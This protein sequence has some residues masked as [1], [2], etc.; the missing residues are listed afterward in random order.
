MFV[1]VAFE[2]QNTVR[3]RTTMGDEKGI[4][5]FSGKFPHGA[6]FLSVH[7][8]AVISKVAIL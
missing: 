7:M 2:M 6:T 4:M 1:Y 8:K 3:E 5:A